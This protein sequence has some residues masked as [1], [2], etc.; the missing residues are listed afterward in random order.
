MSTISSQEEFIVEEYVKKNKSTYEISESLGTY[1]NKVRRTLVKLGVKLRDK[2]KAQSTAIQSGRHKHPTKGT[3]RSESDKIKISEGMFSHWSHMSDEERLK[4]SEMAKK[5]WDSMSDEDRFNLRRA[6]AEA[7]RRAAKEGSKM[8]KFLQEG[9]TKTGRSV[10]FHKKGLVANQNLEIDL[11]LPESRVVIEVDGPSHFFPIWGEENLQKTIKSD[12]HKSGLLLQAGY[13]VLRIRHTTK[14]FSSK[15]QRDL[16]A[17][18]INIL[19]DVEKQF[20][21]KS[22]RFLEVGA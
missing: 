4:R 2:S 9:L 7:V 1:P 11:F 22:E 17:K 13:V 15:R 12:A 14:N 10:I 16:L 6:A 5:Q 18:V 20:P 3:E 19:D 21:A 8:E